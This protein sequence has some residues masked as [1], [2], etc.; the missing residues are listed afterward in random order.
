MSE[1]LELGITG[2]LKQDFENAWYNVKESLRKE[3]K[4]KGLAA[5]EENIS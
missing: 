1:V 4:D 5:I 3:Y 2:Q